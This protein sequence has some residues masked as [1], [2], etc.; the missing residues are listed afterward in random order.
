MNNTLKLMRVNAKLELTLKK[1]EYTLKTK[2]YV[3][4]IEIVW[5]RIKL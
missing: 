1:V 4:S 2:F 5:L 3:N